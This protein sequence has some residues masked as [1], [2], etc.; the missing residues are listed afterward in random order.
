LSFPLPPK[1][2]EKGINAR[3]AD[4]LVWKKVAGL[5]SSP[6][7]LA[8]QV[9]RWFNSRQTKT[10]SALVDAE[11]LKKE[12]GKLNEQLE[13]YNKGYGAGVFTLEQLKG[14]T[15]PLREKISQLETQIANAA[16][17]ASQT[18]LE[19]PSK[20]EMAVFAEKAKETLQGLKFETKR[21]II[22]NTVE[23]VISTQSQLQVIGYIPLNVQLFTHHRNR[24][25]S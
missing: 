8:E 25:T 1:C 3:V 13:R 10:T 5:M 2:E 22:L 4:D 11:A 9:N 15:E 24:G 7:L 6:E 23:R 18:R 21:A 17:E 20:Q 16:N 12:V 14:Y 19:T